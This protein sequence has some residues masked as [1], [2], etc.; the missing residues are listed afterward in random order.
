M[1]IETSQQMYGQEQ[2]VNKKGLLWQS[3]HSKQE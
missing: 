3:E 1:I 2:K